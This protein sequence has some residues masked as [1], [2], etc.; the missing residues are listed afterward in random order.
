MESSL[1]ELTYVALCC[2]SELFAIR[3]HIPTHKEQRTLTVINLFE[4]WDVLDELGVIRIVE[5]SSDLAV[6]HGR[7]PTIPIVLKDGF[8]NSFQIFEI[9]RGVDIRLKKQTFPIA[10]SVQRVRVARN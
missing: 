1:D 8:L 7:C 5:V 10:W 2:L 9:E 3:P 4:L 6:L